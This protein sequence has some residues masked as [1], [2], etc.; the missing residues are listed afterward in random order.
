MDMASNRLQTKT[1][2]TL[3]DAKMAY[4]QGDFYA[5][6]DICSSIRL[7]SSDFSSEVALLKARAY[8]RTGR[9]N[10]AESVLNDSR[11]SHRSLDA[12]VTSQMLEATALVRQ[13]SVD[14]GLEMLLALEPKAKDAHFA[15]RSE[16]NV[17]TALAYWVKRD[18]TTAEQLLERVD[19]RSD[20]IHARALELQAWCQ[21]ARRNYRESA[22]LFRKTLTK[23]D[24]CRAS[25]HA[26]TAT[27]LSSLGIFAAEFFDAD[28]AR[29]V[30]AHTDMIKWSS[31]IAAYRYVILEHQALFYEFAGDTKTAYDFA[32]KAR[33]SATTGPEKVSGYALSALISG[34][35]REFFSTRQ[36]AES[37][38]T[39]LGTL[40]ESSLV[41]EDRFVLLSVAENWSRFEPEGAARLLV[42]YGELSPLE[43]T[44]ASAGD[45]RTEAHEIFVAG[46]VAQARGDT[47]F[48]IRC[49]H[50]AFSTFDSLGYIRRSVIAANA[51]LKLEPSDHLRRYIVDNLAGTE[52]YITAQLNLDDSIKTLAHH[53]LVGELARAQREVVVLVCSGKTNKEIGQLRNVNEQTI[54]NML[55]KNIYPRFGVSSRSAL[56]SVLMRQ[57][58]TPS[59]A[60]AAVLSM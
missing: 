27:A 46:V 34:N 39:L 23:L 21:T 32:M 45:P 59:R 24:H 22:V 17:S 40:D 51:L 5:C 25:D 43:S 19:P 13:D 60:E 35:A 15:V 12:W 52:N 42:R 8:L 33:D 47:A 56:I 44:L 2:I 18:I 10:E 37:A 9:P 28:L 30:A 16:I 50:R 29:F 3:A 36:Y 7:T 6:L 1:R 48:A 26:I 57:V 31:G 11:G 41:G 49:Y 54:K 14:A 53:P 58:V 20:I 55:T 38:L 4:F